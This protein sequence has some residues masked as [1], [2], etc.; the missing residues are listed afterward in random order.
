MTWQ[1]ADE[2]NG[3]ALGERT[4][5]HAYTS[6]ITPARPPYAAGVVPNVVFDEV[7]QSQGSAGGVFVAGR[8]GTGAVA[9]KIPPSSWNQ[10]VFEKYLNGYDPSKQVAYG[11]DPMT[12]DLTVKGWVKIEGGYRGFQ[13]IRIV[14][15]DLA[16]RVDEDYGSPGSPDIWSDYDTDNF[17]LNL[18]YV[19]NQYGSNP[20]NCQVVYR[21]ADW[22][23]PNGYNNVWITQW[24]NIPFNEW[25]Y[26]E[27]RYSA[28]SVVQCIVQSEAGAVL[29][30]TGPV[31]TI[32]GWT[33][34][35][36]NINSPYDPPYQAYPASLFT[37]DYF[38]ATI[39]EPA[40]VI[41]GRPDRVRR[42]FT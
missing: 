8:N 3:G 24:C 34:H 4:I 39:A 26:C 32:T 31:Q 10:I 33:P 37:W 25:V 40:P 17:A 15:T 2:F 12:G 14:T 30:D 36:T 27:L 22:G 16:S 28:A 23:G 18:S 41:T 9:A 1:V 11:P 21:P 5:G 7:Y 38:E 42:L 35:S 19:N 6:G 20:G 29:M 13:M